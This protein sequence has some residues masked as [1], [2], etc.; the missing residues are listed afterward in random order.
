MASPLEGSLAAT[1]GAAMAFL[2]LDAT[3]ARNVAGTITDP[4]DPPVPTE[5]TYACKAIVEDFA[6]RFRLDGTVQ[7]NERK[8][9]ILATT[10]SVTP[11]P[12]DRITIRSTTY[13]VMTVATDP[14]LATWE[15][16]CRS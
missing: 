7:A 4:A 10:L 14:A 11:Q 16:K 5:A 2:F 9:L 8:V 13:T 1:I 3:L 12:N 6:E 15:L